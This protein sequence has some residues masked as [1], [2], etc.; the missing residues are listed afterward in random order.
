AVAD[1]CRYANFASLLL[2]FIDVTAYEQLKEEHERQQVCIMLVSVDNYDE[3]L[4]IA[5]DWE[6][7][8][9]SQIDK[10]IRGWANKIGAAIT[11]Y[12][13]HLYSFTM[14]K[15][16]LD[17][18][19]KDNFPMLD[20]AKSID[21]GGDFPLSLSIGI[22]LGGETCQITDRYAQDA[23]DIAL[24]RGGD[25]AVIKNVED[26]EYYGGKTQGVEKSN[27]GKSRLIAH[28]LRA[29]MNQSSRIFIMGHKNP[30]MDC[31]GA[32]LGISRIAATVGKDTYILLGSYDESMEEMV[33]DA[34]ATGDYEFVSEEKAVSLFKENSLV[35]VVDTH[36]PG[37]V[38]SPELVNMTEKLVA[39]DHHRRAEDVLPHQVLTYMEPYASSASELVA[40]V[41]QYAC[42]KKAL[43]KVE[44]D[45][46]LAGIMLDTNRFAVKAGVRTFEAASWLRRNGADLQTV[47]RYFQANAEAFRIRAACVAG[48]W[49]VSDNVAMSIY[50][51]R[52]VNSQIINSQVADEL[53]TIKGIE[54]SFV[55]GQDQNGETVVS[56]RSLGS[57]N[58]QRIMEQFGG[59][60]HLNTAGARVDMSPEEILKA[61]EEF[62]KTTQ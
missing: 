29:L 56:A 13:D 44:A 50:E 45:G 57:I 3:L 58:V 55:A 21:V 15:E 25:Q 41:V 26:L 1:A 28:A 5:E 48:A 23:L 38:E 39:I 53:L 32:A 18:L 62:F 4:N 9:I 42:E 12:K 2:Y 36:R 8:L 6:V 24:G 61:I 17:E 19:K 10:F 47:R 14:I 40:E 60:G 16:T 49:I 54:A 43:T 37:L 46:L 34:R 31:F 59:G 20:E 11:R 30:D 33:A 27:K 22:G 35:V 52:N 7:E 51:G